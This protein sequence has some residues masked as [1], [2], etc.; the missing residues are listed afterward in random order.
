MGQL[1]TRVPQ[2]ILIHANIPRVFCVL[3]WHGIFY[4]TNEGVT[5]NIAV[6]LS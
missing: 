5:E 4:A 3:N 6:L 1:E 2:V